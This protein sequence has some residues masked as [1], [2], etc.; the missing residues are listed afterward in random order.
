MQ[1]PFVDDEKPFI[2]R[3]HFVQQGLGHQARFQAMGL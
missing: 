3:F 1:K 2:S